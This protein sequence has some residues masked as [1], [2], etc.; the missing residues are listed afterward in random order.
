[1]SELNDIERAKILSRVKKMMTLANNAGATEGE[2]D[3]AMR[4]AHATLA[5]YN[6]SMM[7]AEAAGTE[8]AEKRDKMYV[9]TRHAWTRSVAAGIARLFFCNYFFVTLR[10]AG[11]LRHYFVGRASNALTAQLMMEYVV[12]SINRE[13]RKRAV[14]ASRL[15]GDSK[16]AYERNFAKGAAQRV[17]ERCVEIQEAAERAPVEVVGSKSTALVLASFYK[18]EA[19]ANTAFI[20][21]ELNVKLEDTNDRQRPAGAG[22]RDG[23]E[24]GDRVSL[25]RQLGGKEERKSL[26]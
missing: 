11:K 26:K 23:K 22:Y 17:W 8:K 25:N 1:M 21:Q 15:Y 18:Q 24:F 5:K 3:N 2:R 4:M 20:E 6:L 12:E 10:H 13:G 16:G 19:E 7:E 9:D 14:D